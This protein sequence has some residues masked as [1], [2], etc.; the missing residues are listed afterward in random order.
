[1]AENSRF[2]V[3][4]LQPGAAI[5]SAFPTLAPDLEVIVNQVRRIN[6]LDSIRHVNFAPLC[7]VVFLDEMGCMVVTSEWDEKVKWPP[8]RG[9]RSD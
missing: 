9:G 4:A 1:L 5:G 8:D 6:S 2:S 7:I 3:I